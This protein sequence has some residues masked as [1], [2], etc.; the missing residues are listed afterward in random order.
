MISQWIRHAP[1]KRK[2]MAVVLLVC[3]LALS[4]TAAAMIIA[5]NIRFKRDFVRELTSRADMVALNS[6]PAM[7]FGDERTSREN[8]QVLSGHADIAVAALYD[9]DG[10]LFAYYRRD[11]M[12][13]IPLDVPMRLPVS[14]LAEQ[15]TFH[16]RY[17]EFSRAVRAA[18]EPIGQILIRASLK[19]LHSRMWAAVEVLAATLV[20]VLLIAAVLAAR[21]Q[22]AITEPVLQLAATMRQVSS[23]RDY[24]IRASHNSH[25]EVGELITGFNHM[26]A[27]VEVRESELTGYRDHLERL[28]AERTTE[29]S[30]AR[31]EALRANR[32]KSIFLANMSHEIRTPMNA[33]LGYA[34]VLRN[35]SPVDEQQAQAIA[36][37]ENAGMHLLELIND[38][39]DL[40]KVEAG[41]MELHPTD[42]DLHELVTVL[43][44]M[45]RIRCEQ[46][47]LEW[48]IQSEV[49]PGTLVHADQGKLRQ[50]LINLLGNAVKFTDTGYV[51]FS[52]RR[53]GAS[54]E[55]EVQDSGAGI[56]PEQQANL[57]EPFQQ[58][59]SGHQKGG[60]GLGLALVKRHLE[61]MGSA[62]EFEM[63]AGTGACFWFVLALPPALKALPATSAVTAEPR[64]CEQ[65]LLCF[66]VDD[67]E[68]N[69]DVMRQLLEHAGMQVQVF[70]DGQS[71]LTELIAVEILPTLVFMD[72]R[73]PG[74]DGFTVLDRIRTTP[75][76][77]E[78]KVVAV[79]ASSFE[80]R[81]EAYLAAGFNGFLPKPVVF[82]ALC[83][84]IVQLTGAKFV[85]AAPVATPEPEL[86]WRLPA[87]LKKELKRA[88]QFADI[89]RLRQLLPQLSAQPSL[90]SRFESCLS[91]YDVEGLM[92]ILDEVQD[93]PEA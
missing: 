22:R 71:V 3:V 19:E 88:V 29:L 15:F 5:D 43:D 77:A 26:L 83:Q 86:G 50:V 20:A 14:D 82:S 55:F 25:D 34:Q 48:R 7:A 1:L 41:A 63:V 56:A 59:D 93:E 87:V 70:S 44:Q 57:F 85:A 58:G 52:L 6:A 10:Q 78:L 38:I 68:G 79:T 60:T 12:A 53:H 45:L 69:R 11:A 64:F 89:S 16:D 37:I 24:S 72:I 31:D 75:K 76:L 81:P 36:A 39:L 91:R 28:V 74:M 35:R 18:E 23:E 27:Q 67:V 33:V 4:V 8:L 40:S 80:R 92:R 61:L 46:K 90:R 84:V 66:V 32:A 17:L 21:L 9:R 30:R 65:P 73:M 47:G 51:C 49:L 62:I 2:L 54:Y 13:D 42:F